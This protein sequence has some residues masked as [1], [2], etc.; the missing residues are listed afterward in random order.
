VIAASVVWLVGFS[1]VLAAHKVLVRGAR[2]L[3]AQHI[4]AV[5]AVPSGQPLI[6]LD[7][8]AIE[9]RLRTMPEI[10]SATVRTSYPSTVVVT[11]RERV[12]VG[13]RSSGGGAELVD[14]ADVGFRSQPEPPAG[15]PRL[16]AAGD[17]G[18]AALVA[19]ALPSRIAGQV[20]VITAPTPESV[21]LTLADGR[22]VVWGG[23]D[24]SADK[25]RLLPAL[26]GQPGRYFD[27]SD[28]DSVISRGAGN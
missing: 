6:R 10:R 7:T 1:G 5:A 16:N 15:L 12:A 23:P 2:L 25:A 18:A 20:T 8:G 26:L 22:T 28:P 14:E 4:R 21:T 11:V 17:S 9:A 13:Y 27:V 24:R 3:S 19:A